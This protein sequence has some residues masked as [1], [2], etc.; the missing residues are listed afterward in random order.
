LLRVYAAR[1]FGDLTPAMI[2]QLKEGV[3]LEDGVAHFESVDDAGGTG[4]NHWYHV[5]LREGRN[6]EVRRMFEAVGVPVSRLI[7]I[8]Y[9]DLVLPPRLR[10]GKWN[11]LTAEEAEALA[12][13]LSMPSKKALA[14][15]SSARPAFRSGTRSSPLRGQAPRVEQGTEAQN[16]ARRKPGARSN[17]RINEARPSTERKTFVVRAGRAERQETVATA[18]GRPV[19]RSTARVGERG[20]RVDAG[21]GMKRG[22]TREPG[23]SSERTA[24]HAPSR[25]AGRDTRDVAGRGRPAG[26][27]RA[28]RKR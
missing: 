1:I 15:N 26:D 8:Q 21:Q 19:A 2:Q 18:E 24:S 20:S 14:D 25:P 28:P 4:M 7:R 11:M 6:R 16:D 10:P 27:G 13:S 12:V 17:A 23:R 3:E 22:A 5:G 9:G